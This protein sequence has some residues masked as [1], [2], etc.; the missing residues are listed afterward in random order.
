MIL[1]IWGK[2][3]REDKNNLTGKLMQPFFECA[4]LFVFGRKMLRALVCRKRAK[5]APQLK[6][7]GFNLKLFPTSTE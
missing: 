7:R 6:P 3:S 1:L 2:K 4:A 5:F